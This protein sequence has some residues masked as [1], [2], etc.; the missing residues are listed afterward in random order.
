LSILPPA[1]CSVA[2]LALLAPLPI[3][4]F[5]SITFESRGEPAGWV[6]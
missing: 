3:L 5:T 4:D 2:L 6:R 1:A